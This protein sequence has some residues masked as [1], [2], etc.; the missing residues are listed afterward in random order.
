MRFIITDDDLK[1]DLIG[2]INGDINGDP[3]S[4]EYT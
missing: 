1:G 2:D 4:N 3:S